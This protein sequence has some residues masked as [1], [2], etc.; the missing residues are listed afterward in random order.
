MV[1]VHP[2]ARKHGIADEDIVHAVEHALVI[3][4]QTRDRWL[5]L[6]PGRDVSLIEVI[7][8]DRPHAEIAIHAMKM[9]RKYRGL[10]EGRR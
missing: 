5:Y 7:T 2:A 9:R 3:E 10:L 4:S 1:E 6:G 8:L